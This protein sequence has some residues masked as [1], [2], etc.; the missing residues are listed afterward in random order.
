MPDNFSQAIRGG[1]MCHSKAGLAIGSGDTTALD[2]A[3]PNGAGIDF[4][5]NG[6]LY[7]LADGADKAVTAQAVQAISTSCMYIVQLNSSG[8]LSTVKGKEVLTADV[9]S[10]KEALTFPQPTED[11][12]VIGAVR[13]DT[14]ASVTFTMGTTAFSAAGITDTYY[15]YMLLPDSPIVS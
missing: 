1:T 15:D 3:A 9:T 4:A 8:T 14:N 6:I 5:I 11:N 13:V 12:C 2:V 7:H 10:G